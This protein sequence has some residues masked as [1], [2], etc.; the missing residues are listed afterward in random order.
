MV[1]YLSTVFLGA[2]NVH[3]G[4]LRKNVRTLSVARR[5]TGLVH[6]LLKFAVLRHRRT[7]ISASSDA[8]KTIPDEGLGDRFNLF[9]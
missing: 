1:A 4:R 6:F 9:G 7:V 8:P 3:V 5:R 2:R